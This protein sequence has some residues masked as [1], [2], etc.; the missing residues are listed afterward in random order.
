MSSSRMSTVCCGLIVAAALP[1]SASTAEAQIF[2]GPPR[3]RVIE[4]RRPT[5][6]YSGFI[7]HGARQYYCDY[8]RYPNRTCSVDRRGRERCRVTGW[9]MVQRCN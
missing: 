2:L 7:R 8:V 6:G 5:H 9:R 3:E 1:G 4:S